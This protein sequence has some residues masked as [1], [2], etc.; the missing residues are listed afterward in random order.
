MRAE[1]HRISAQILLDFKITQARIN[2]STDGDMY[3]S[4][5]TGPQ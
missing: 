5:K 2:D 4:V 1:L 3:A